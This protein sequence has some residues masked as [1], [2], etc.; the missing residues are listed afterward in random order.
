MPLLPVPHYRQHEPGECLAACSAMALEYLNLPVD[1][2]KLVA[3]LKIIR[4][5]GA[6]FRNLRSLESLGVKVIIDHGELDT[7][8]ACLERGLPPI[9]LVDTAQLSYWHEPTA[10]AV[11]V[12]GVEGDLIHLNDPAFHDAPKI[13]PIREFELAWIDLD[14]FYASVQLE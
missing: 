11:V 6:P 1:Y 7:L 13:I 12:V 2:S 3:Q 9:T 10:H 4:K 5:A 8:H 14:Q